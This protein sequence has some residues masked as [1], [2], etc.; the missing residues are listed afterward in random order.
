M[1]VSL[2]GSR[3][4]STSFLLGIGFVVCVW[5]RFYDFY[6]LIR[7]HPS[8]SIPAIK[9]LSSRAAPNVSRSIIRPLICHQASYFLRSA[10]RV[11]SSHP[12]LSLRGFVLKWTKRCPSIWLLSPLSAIATCGC[13]HFSWP[14]ADEAWAEN[15]EKRF[16]G[17]TCYSVHWWLQIL[18]AHGLSLNIGADTFRTLQINLI[19]LFYEN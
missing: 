2:L 6:V 17:R 13:S 16:I 19:L 7:R 5:R 11:Q 8:P 3:L 1:F 9:S 12:A 14:I 18:Y 10:S 4:W 15:K